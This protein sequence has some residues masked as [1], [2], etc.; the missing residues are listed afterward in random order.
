MLVELLL[1]PP[2]HGALL[3]M[4]HRP[5]E[6]GTVL[7]QRRVRGRGSDLDLGPPPEEKPQSASSPAHLAV[8]N[9][10]SGSRPPSP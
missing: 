6:R 1:P 7:L 3:N 4:T 2:L 8:I 9:R 10:D 5:S